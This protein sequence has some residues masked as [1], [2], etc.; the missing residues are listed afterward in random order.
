MGAPFPTSELL[1]ENV[2]SK[3]MLN[4]PN[5]N[6]KSSQKFAGDLEFIP[7]LRTCSRITQIISVACELVRQTEIISHIASKNI[8]DSHIIAPQADS[9]LSAAIPEHIH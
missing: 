7:L 4:I 5:L 1:S 3:P 6:K 2:L 8:L 9:R